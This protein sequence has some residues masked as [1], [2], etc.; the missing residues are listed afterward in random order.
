[1]GH[2]IKRNFDMY[3]SDIF[4]LISVVFFCLKLQVKYYFD[5]LEI[6]QSPIIAQ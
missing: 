1:M 2:N 3:Q 6:I 5:N 4:S